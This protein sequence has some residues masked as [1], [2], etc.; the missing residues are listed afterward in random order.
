MLNLLP[1]LEYPLSS[2]MGI[3]SV[4]GIAM[5]TSLVQAR[6]WSSPVWCALIILCGYLTLGLCQS[7]DSQET[8]CRTWTLAALVCLCRGTEGLR[9][10]MQDAAAA[11]RQYAISDLM[12]LTM[13]L[14]FF[15]AGIRQ[16][17]LSQ[18]EPL[19]WVGMILIGAVLPC[20]V[21]SLRI[22]R[23]WSSILRV[24]LSLMGAATV[25]IGLA[26][27]EC[28]LLQPDRIGLEEA[29]IRYSSLMMAM[30]APRLLFQII[31]YAWAAWPSQKKYEHNDTQ[32]VPRNES[33]GADRI[34]VEQTQPAVKLLA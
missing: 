4:Y 23:P 16:T 12:I 11:S 10:R 28:T 22:E 18:R 14:A 27:A 20:C 32:A 3:G 8:I 1:V 17:S 13:G 15:A 26:W 9:Q 6:R 29:F 30:M 21:V 31:R 2:E 19:F 7:W 34:A 33:P 5:A 25:A 24:T